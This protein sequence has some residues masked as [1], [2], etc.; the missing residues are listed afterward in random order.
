MIQEN[1]NIIEKFENLELL[2]EDGII[3]RKRVMAKELY[4]LVVERIKDFLLSEL[5]N[6]DQKTIA[7]LDELVK[8]LEEEKTPEFDPNNETDENGNYVANHPEKNKG[9]SIAQNL[10]ETAK[11]KLL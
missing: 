7:L 5:Q 2:G 10:I 1:K 9:I 6:K 4:P 3:I 11:K 8:E